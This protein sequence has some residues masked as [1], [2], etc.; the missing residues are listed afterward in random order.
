MFESVFK[1]SEVASTNND[2]LAIPPHTK[3]GLNIDP[4][5]YKDSIYLHSHSFYPSHL[6]FCH[7]LLNPVPQVDRHTLGLEGFN[8][9]NMKV[10]TFY[11]AREGGG[12]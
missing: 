10:P 5:D 12:R 3:Q 11:S 2:H 1:F 9:G 4:L 7:P 8:T 6:D